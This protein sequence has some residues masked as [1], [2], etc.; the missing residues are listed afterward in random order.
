M[1]LVL[2]AMH[3]VGVAEEVPYRTAAE[4]MS[5]PLRNPMDPALD[6]S[7]EAHML[8]D[9][10][11][12]Q[13]GVRRPFP[14]QVADPVLGPLYRARRCATCGRLPDAVDAE[15]AMCSLCKDPAAGRFCCKEPCFREAWKKGHRNTCA[16]RDKGGKGPAGAKKG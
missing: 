3:S 1:K 12:S 8:H 5:V 14:D 6:L 16:G 7:C 15:F 2:A 10:S 13:T 9:F 11:S 4:M